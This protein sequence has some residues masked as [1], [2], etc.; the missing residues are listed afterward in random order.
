MR[1]SDIHMRDPFVVPVASEGLYYLFGSTDAD[2]WGST[3]GVGFNCFTSRDLENWEGPIPAF[4]PPTDFW[5]QGEFWAPECHAY[6]GDYYLFATFNGSTRWRG[7]QILRSTSGRPEGPY[8][9]MGPYP[10]TPA[11]WGC[12]DGTLFVDDANCPWMIFCHEWSQIKIG[13]IEA[14]PL[15][16]DLSEAAGPPVTLF[17]ANAPSWARDLVEHP[18]C[19]V[20]D[21]PYLYHEDGRLFMLWSGFSESGYTM[22]LA[23]SESGGPLGPWRQHETPIYTAD[24]GHGMRFLTFDGQ[25]MVAV[26][27]PNATPQERP[28][29][30]PAPARLTR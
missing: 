8:A 3:S 9:V 5:S 1:L 13:T 26:H 17:H 14:M 29:F 20:T 4:R 28:I 16:D 30:F 10:V 11:D 6:R 27:T 24:G 22:G 12:L 23:E 7:T 21:G 15:K 25:P 18:G 19:W 2:I